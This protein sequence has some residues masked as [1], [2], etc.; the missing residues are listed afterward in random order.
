MLK[1]ITLQEAVKRYL[2]HEQVRVWHD[3]GEKIEV[4]DIAEIFEGYRFIAEGTIEIYQVQPSKVP[5]KNSS[6]VKQIKK[7]IDEGKVTA[8]RN[9]GWSQAKIAD[10]MGVS[11]GTISSL[12]KKLQNDEWENA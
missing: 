2:D 1:E 8:L 11:Q 9:A 6:E 10:E 4:F 7:K 12:L 3:S 5:K